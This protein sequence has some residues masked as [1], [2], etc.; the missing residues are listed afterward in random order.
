M[1]FLGEESFSGYG[2][3][4]LPSGIFTKLDLQEQEDYSILLYP[5]PVNDYL[6]IQTNFNEIDFIEIIDM[7]GKSVLTTTES[8]NINVSNL[9]EG[10]YIVN[11][12]SFL[13]TITQKFVKSN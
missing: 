6:Q 1:F 3:P 7:T 11:V 8:T 12:H 2:L 5:S 4:N 10:H 13:G 9:V